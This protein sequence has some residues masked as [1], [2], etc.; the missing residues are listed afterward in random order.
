VRSHPLLDQLA[1]G[2]MR[3]G[4]G[5]IRDFMHFLGEPQA[6]YPAVH[7]AGTNGKGSTCAFVTSILTQ[8]GYTVGTTLSPHIEEVNE[9]VLIN[10]IP[11]DD[12]TLVEGLEAIDR[13][14]WDW[15]RSAGFSGQPLTY[16]EMMIATALLV[17]ARRQVD[18]AV[19]EVGLG[20]RLDASRVV[21]PIVS[22]VTHV[23]LDHTEHLGDTLEAIAAEKA[24]IF[25]RGVPVVAGAMPAEAMATIEAFARR[26][27]A[28]LWR[29]GPQ[30]RRSCRSGR[31]SFGTPS[32]GVGEV[33]LGLEGEHQGSNALVAVG[34]AHQLRSL[35]F[36]L[37][38]QHIRDGLGQAT[39]SARLEQLLPGL[40][41]D[42]AHNV[43]GARALA[44]WLDGRPR[45][46]SRILLWGMGGERQPTG[47]IEPLLPHFDEVV[48]TSCA[49][50]KAK[51]AMELAVALQDLDVVLSV[52]GAIEQA[53]PEVYTEVEETIVSGS[54][55]V[56]GAARSLVRAGALDGL[57]PGRGPLEVTEVEE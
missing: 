22:A 27:G 41:I 38:D 10:G 5:R 49:H 1:N 2:G 18:I 35:G 26:N 53:L 31:W 44:A 54:L 42:G 36:A 4:L 55:F 34:I 3:L 21:R 51:D 47:I 45:P 43:D 40:I 14:R 33:E 25:Q 9:R 46:A 23:G 28:P 6:A 57:A 50:P 20:G 8:A 48:T 29:P 7:I 19:V 12:G 17:F 11:V 13:A 37:D 30:L 39:L 15:A 16:F 52:G 24:G 32:G 56:A